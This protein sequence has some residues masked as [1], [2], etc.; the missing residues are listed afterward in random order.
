MVQRDLS[1]DPLVSMLKKKKKPIAK[2]HFHDPSTGTGQKQEDPGNSV[3]S[4]SSQI[5][6]L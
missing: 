5:S 3:V 4:Q 2:T 1:S 6:E